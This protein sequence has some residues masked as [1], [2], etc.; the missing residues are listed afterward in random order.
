MNFWLSLGIV[1]YAVSLAVLWQNKNFGHGDA[2]L[3]LIVFGFFFPL[4]A[5]LATIRAKPLVVRVQQSTAEMWLLFGCLVAVSLY[6][7]WGAALLEVFF[8]IRLLGSDRVK[9]AIVLGRKLVVF[10]AVP[11]LLFRVLFKYRWADFGLQRAGLR[12]L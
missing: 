1:A 9:F 11:F 3:E 7:I 2:I 5:W 8:P 4:V 10:V 6:L 12:A